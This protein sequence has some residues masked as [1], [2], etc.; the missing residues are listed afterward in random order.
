LSATAICAAV[1]LPSSRPT[2]AAF[3]DGLLDLRFD[4]VERTSAM[5]EAAQTNSYAVLF[6]HGEAHFSRPSPRQD[7]PAILVRGVTPVEY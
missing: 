3:D 5:S 6:G 2:G 1:V 7:C 4:A